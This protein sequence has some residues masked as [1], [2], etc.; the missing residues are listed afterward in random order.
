[1]DHAQDHLRRRPRPLAD[2]VERRLLRVRIHI[3]NDALL[4]L[5]LL[6]KTGGAKLLLRLRDKKL[7]ARGAIFQ[8]SVHRFLSLQIYSHFCPFREKC[9]VF[10]GDV[11]TCTKITDKRSTR[12]HTSGRLPFIRSSYIY[13]TFNQSI[14]GKALIPKRNPQ[15][16]SKST[17]KST[18]SGMK[19]FHTY[20]NRK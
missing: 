8:I 18:P 14:G 16:F 10:I 13:S 9:A 12:L 5:A 2:L 3:A 7:A 6:I 15:A 1:M 17:R 11:K 4:F 19:V 20:K